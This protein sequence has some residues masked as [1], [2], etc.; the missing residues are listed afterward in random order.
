MFELQG[1]LVCLV[2]A[3]HRGDG[4]L[5]GCLPDLL[6]LG[7]SRGHRDAPRLSS[8]IT[9]YAPKRAD[10][11]AAAR[12]EKCTFGNRIR[13][14]LTVQSWEV[15]LTSDQLR[16]ATPFSARIAEHYIW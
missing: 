3:G 15:C 7:L 2:P 1:K 16:K 8:G 4:H 5:S 11:K 6:R 9:G 13:L 14:E 12:P 10:P